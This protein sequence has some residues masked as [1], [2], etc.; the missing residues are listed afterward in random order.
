MF[1]FKRQVLTSVVMFKYV[2]KILVAGSRLMIKRPK[3]YALKHSQSRLTEWLHH[4]AAQRSEFQHLYKHIFEEEVVLE[5]IVPA[6]WPSWQP[7][8]C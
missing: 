3:S 1:E 8:T 5:H 6:R 2:Q 4:V 7:H